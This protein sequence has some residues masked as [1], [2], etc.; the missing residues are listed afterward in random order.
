MNI[1]RWRGNLAES[2]KR[3][4]GIPARD[5]AVFLHIEVHYVGSCPGSALIQILKDDPMGYRYRMTKC[6]EDYESPGVS[7]F[8]MY[9]E[10]AHV[11]LG[12][13]L[14]IPCK[15][16]WSKESACEAFAVAMQF[17]IHGCPVFERFSDSNRFFDEWGANGHIMKDLEQR[18]GTVILWLCKQ[19]GRTK[20]ADP[21]L[22]LGFEFLRLG[23]KE[24]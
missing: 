16:E 21:L 7:S 23:A 14:S 9:H 8:V 17:A 11:L 1:F 10:I 15:P 6:S 4:R 18:T 3:Y 5:L 2:Y 22:Q 20:A 19:S 12:E 24:K 13:D